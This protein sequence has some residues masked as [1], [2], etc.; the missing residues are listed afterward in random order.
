MLVTKETVNFFGRLMAKRGGYT[1][2]RRTS[3]L[4]LKII[5]KIFI[6]N[7]VES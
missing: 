1:G 4:F 6:K 5:S 3:N 7:R 2:D